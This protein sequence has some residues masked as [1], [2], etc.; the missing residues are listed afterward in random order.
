[1]ATSDQAGG[2]LAALPSGLTARGEVES[3]SQMN[4]GKPPSLRR[5]IDQLR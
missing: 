4:E 2:A 1:M 5:D 3:K